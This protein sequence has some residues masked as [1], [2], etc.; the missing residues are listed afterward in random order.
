MVVPQ[1][2]S[3]ALSSLLPV[4]FERKTLIAAGELTNQNLGGKKSVGPKGWQSA[5]IV[6]KLCVNLCEFQFLGHQL[7]LCPYQG[8]K[9]T[10]VKNIENLY[11]QINF[12]A[13]W[14]TNSLMFSTCYVTCKLSQIKVNQV[15]Q[16]LELLN[17]ESIYFCLCA[18]F[19]MLKTISVTQ[20]M[21]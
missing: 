1:P 2:C 12:S 10:F 9:L 17:L 14:S 3:Q 15:N 11:S 19:W 8:L 4:L 21:S 16:S 5:L 6:D 20:L 7:K 18:L 13:A